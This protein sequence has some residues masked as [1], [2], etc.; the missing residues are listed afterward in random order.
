MLP[1][2]P[3]PS[4]HN[5]ACNGG[6]PS[7]RVPAS[8]HRT[9]ARNAYPI[10]EPTTC[11]P[12]R[13]T[14]CHRRSRHIAHNQPRPTSPQS[15]RALASNWHPPRESSPE[16]CTEARFAYD[17]RRHCSTA[18]DSPRTVHVS[19][20]SRQSLPLTPRVPSCSGPQHHWVAYLVIPDCPADFRHPHIRLL[21]P[22]PRDASSYSLG[23]ASA[24]AVCTQ[25]VSRAVPLVLRI[26][27]HSG[28]IL[29][30]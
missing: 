18:D 8:R 6:T 5:H 28:N 21:P 14:P 13:R 9:A 1:P 24:L 7:R 26:I 22:Y 12:G 23:T 16:C 17:W 19:S 20:G 30:R 3:P 11:R 25:Y 2:R 27:C 10:P 29:L 15:W 4:H